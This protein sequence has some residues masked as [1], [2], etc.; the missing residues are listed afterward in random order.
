MPLRRRSLRGL[1]GAQFLSEAA[2]GIVF[3]ALPL[4]VY[5]RTDSAIAMAWSSMGAL[6][7]GAVLGVVGGILADRYDRQRVL[8]LSMFVRAVFLVGAWLAGPLGITVALG[9]A[10]R[11][12]GQIDNPSFDALIPGQAKGDLQQVLALRRFIQSVSIIIGPAIGAVAVALVGEKRTLGVAAA[13]FV[14]AMAV[15]VTL[16][17]LDTNLAERRAEQHDSSWLDLA[18]GMSIVATTPFVRRLLAY[19]VV[20]CAA[21]AV[22]M[23]AAVVWF[24]RTLD[25]PDYWYGIAMSAYGLGA[26]G[27]TFLFGGVTFRSPLPRILLIASPVYAAACAM[28][29][30]ANVPAL[31]PIGWL[32]WG[33]SLGPEIV[34]GEIEFVERI[35]EKLLGRAYA[36]LNAALTGGMALG[37]LAAGPI[38]DTISPRAATYLMAA[39]LAATG[40]MWLGP[41]LRGR[42]AGPAMHVLVT[43][44]QLVEERTGL[45]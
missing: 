14:A 29:V 16:R 43:E 37:Y 42:A 26:A 25:V 31:L 34:R 20:Q 44:P 17:H 4:Y 24:E 9:I 7:G 1:V 27:A 2:D 35:D 30:V 5:A 21:I 18:R 11:A 13:M 41:A 19:W 10:A 8:R 3:V 22:A 40:L 39:V 23:A 36:G 38:L 45:H 28:C 6:L 33:I 32:L 12:F 15:H